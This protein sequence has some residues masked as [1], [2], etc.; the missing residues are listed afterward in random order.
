MTYPVIRKHDI[1]VQRQVLPG[2]A[3]WRKYEAELLDIGIVSEDVHPRI[4]GLQKFSQVMMKTREEK[5]RE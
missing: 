4:R 2:T 3:G 5:A 1:K